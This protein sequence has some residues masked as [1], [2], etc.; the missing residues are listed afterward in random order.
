MEELDW[1]QAVAIDRDREIVFAP[2][3]HNSGRWP[4]MNNRSLWG[5][6]LIRTRGASI[7]FGGDTA[8]EAHFAAI[9]ARYGAV[10]LA[11]L[12]IGAYE[13]RKMIDDETLPH[14]S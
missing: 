8:Y 3:Q 2:A 9:R 12:P 10:D 5:S 14:E 4:W 6:F 7:Y 1:W 11:F 13:P